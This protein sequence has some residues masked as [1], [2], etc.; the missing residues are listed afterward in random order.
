VLRKITVSTGISPTWKCG[1][2][3]IVRGR[4]R[5]PLRQLNRVLARHPMSLRRK[6]GNK[7]TERRVGPGRQRESGRWKA[8]DPDCMRRVP[9]GLGSIRDVLVHCVIDLASGEFD[10]KDRHIST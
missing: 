8:P 10:G 1:L 6:R 5:L 7:G 9:R 4:K 3:K 2:D